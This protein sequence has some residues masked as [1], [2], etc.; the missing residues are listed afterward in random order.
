MD[1][2]DGRELRIDVHVIIDILLRFARTSISRLGDFYEEGERHFTIGLEDLKDQT[3]HLTLEEWD[4][5]EDYYLE[6]RNYFEELME[7]KKHFSI[8]GLF[9]V[10][11]IFLTRIMQEI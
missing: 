7:L 9:T 4:K 1:R 8:V 10:F 5:F 2:L 6:H 3:G 11:E